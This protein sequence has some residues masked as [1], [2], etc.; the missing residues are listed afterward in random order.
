MLVSSLRHVRRECCLAAA[1]CITAQCAGYARRSP[2]L[3]ARATLCERP[4]D[5]EARHFG[6]RCLSTPCMAIGC[7]RDDWDDSL[8]FVF[9]VGGFCIHAAHAECKATRSVVDKT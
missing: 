7:N 8:L 2:T 6:K 9:F 3:T 5:V 1:F 4:K